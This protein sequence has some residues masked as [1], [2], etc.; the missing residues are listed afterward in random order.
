MSA[1]NDLRSELDC[2]EANINQLFKTIGQQAVEITLLKKR[3]EKL[4]RIK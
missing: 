2:M 3:I 4:E 1:G